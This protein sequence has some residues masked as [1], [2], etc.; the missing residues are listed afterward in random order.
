MLT[1]A[2]NAPVET[3]DPTHQA[4][5]R[6]LERQIVSELPDPIGRNHGG[7]VGAFLNLCDWVRP[8]FEHGELIYPAEV[9]E[10]TAPVLA[11]TVRAA[12]RFDP[13][14]AV[15][16]WAEAGY[17]TVAVL[18]YQLAADARRFLAMLADLRDAHRD[19]TSALFLDSVALRYATRR[20]SAAADV[21]N[22]LPIARRMRDIDAEYGWVYLFESLPD[23]CRAGGVDFMHRMLREVPEFTSAEPAPFARF[24]IINALA[25]T[26]RLVGDLR[27]ALDL[28]DAAQAELTVSDI[29]PQ[30][31]DRYLGLMDSNRAL[32]LYDAGNAEEAEEAIKRAVEIAPYRP[33]RWLHSERG[34]RIAIGLGKFDSW[35]DFLSA[36][37]ELRPV[38]FDDD[39]LYY[40][41]RRYFSLIPTLVDRLADDGRGGEAV[42]LARHALGLLERHVPRWQDQ[43]AR[44]AA[45]S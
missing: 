6:Y 18:G 38:A 36:H 26:A 27:H 42:G 40:Q 30:L 41:A 8:I 35:Y 5:L 4:L 11:D 37:G 25:L 31:R 13:R 28:V 33:G 14:R 1:A 29:D 45:R 43:R 15:P 22:L 24:R 2:P 19:E 10:R 21:D 44:L 7:Y 34:F 39:D 23:A 16:T 20:T 3:P 17:P 32:L 9:V 12:A